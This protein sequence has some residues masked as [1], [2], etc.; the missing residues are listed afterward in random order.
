M[1]SKASSY[2]VRATSTGE[3]S[4]VEASAKDGFSRKV[5]ADEY[6]A[7]EEGDFKLPY[8]DYNAGM[9]MNTSVEVSNA[10]KTVKANFVNFALLY[11]DGS[12]SGRVREASGSPGNITVGADSLRHVRCR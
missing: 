3:Y 11:V 5:A 12:I 10:A 4:A 1:L 8:W 2:Y 7:V 9:T 6:P